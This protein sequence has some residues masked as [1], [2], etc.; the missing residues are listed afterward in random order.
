MPPASIAV[1]RL[2]GQNVVNDDRRQR[3]KQS[4]LTV[5]PHACPDCGT[6]LIVEHDATATRWSCP[7]CGR[8]VTVIEDSTAGGFDPTAYYDPPSKRC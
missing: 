5:E 4:P 2:D 8:D 1:Y 7:K 3:M 6:E